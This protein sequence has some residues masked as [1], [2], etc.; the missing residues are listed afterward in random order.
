MR[1]D[2]LAVGGLILLGVAAA[3]LGGPKVLNKARLAA[4]RATGTTFRS[5]VSNPGVRT[6]ADP[7]RGMPA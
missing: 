5:G 7:A 2:R 4:R 6:T 1:N 3:G